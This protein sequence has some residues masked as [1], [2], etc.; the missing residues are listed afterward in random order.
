LNTILEVFVERAKNGDKRALEDVI[1]GI[2]DLI[3]GLAIRM[4]WHPS[5][6]E[7]ATQEILIKIITHLDG[8]RGESSFTSC[9]TLRLNP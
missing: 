2:Q 9:G 8:F 6:A 4:L 7:D 5:D 1:R 3:Y